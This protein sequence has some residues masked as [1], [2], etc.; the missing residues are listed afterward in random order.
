M[1]H[2][3]FKVYNGETVLKCFLS[4][5]LKHTPENLLSEVA[6]AQDEITGDHVVDWVQPGS[7]P[8]QASGTEQL[9][10]LLTVCSCRYIPPLHHSQ[11]TRLASL[12]PD[13]RR[14]S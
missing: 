12:Q 1:P 2:L 10:C 14:N 5:R 3:Q 11:S 9:Q 8:D 4:G 6:F 13:V 7:R